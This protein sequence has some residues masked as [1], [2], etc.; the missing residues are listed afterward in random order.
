MSD[1]APKN[2]VGL[3]K[4]VHWFGRM[5]RFHDAK[6]LNIALHSNEP[7]S[8]RIHAFQMTDKVDEQGC[9][10]LDKHA[11]VTISVQEITSVSLTD[12]NLPGIIHDLHIADTGDGAQVTWSSSYGVEGTL[13]AKR[14]SI[15]LV[16]GLP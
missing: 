3:D 8:L 9:F 6:L 2:V 11:V 16:P 13:K 14:V 5:P 7:S 1:S 15:D 10:V 4:L 12:F